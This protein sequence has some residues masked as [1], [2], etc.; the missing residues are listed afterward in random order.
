MKGVKNKICDKNITG[1][2]DILGFGSKVLAIKD[3]DEKNRGIG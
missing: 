1:F 2:I 3:A